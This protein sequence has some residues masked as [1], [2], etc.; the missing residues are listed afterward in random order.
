MKKAFITGIT[1]Q[2]GSY[3]AEILLEKGYQVIA[4]VRRV[5]ASNFERITHLLNHPALTIEE[6]ELS[7]AGSIYGL[8]EKHKPDEVYNLGAQSHVK[9]SFDQPDFTFQVNTMGVL[10][11]LEAIRRF[12]PRTRFYQASTSEMFGKN[13]TEKDGEKFQDEDTQFFPQ[14]P[15]AVAKMASHNLVRIYR[16]GYGMFGSCGILFNHESERRGEH[17]VTRKIT[18]WIGKFKAWLDAQNGAALSFDA[19]HIYAGESKFAKLRLG[20]LD[21]F[22]DWGHARDYVM[23]MW[24]ILQQEVA[25]D[26]VVAT[27]ETY[28]VRQFLTEAFKHIDVSDFTAFVVVDP[29]FYRPAE[30]E[31]LRGMPHKAKRVLGWTPDIS[32]AELAKRM[33]LSDIEASKS[34]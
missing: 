11:L 7:D 22:R 15:Y 32:F 24:M 16:E 23:A 3:L 17:F 20:N 12:S 34:I 6:G 14:S 30:V 13:F 1:G 31:F 9:T 10:N 21:A 19:D 33:V 2:D 27:G 18:V 5:S 29:Q 28:T 8:I 25:D 26:F 4:L